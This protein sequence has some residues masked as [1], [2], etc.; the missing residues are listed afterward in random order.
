MDLRVKIKRLHKDAVIPQ[1]SKE[2]DAGLDLTAVDKYYDVNG[3]V[4]YKTGIAVEIPEG[5]VGLIYPRSSVSRV[6]LF[7]VNSVGVIDSGF[8][9]EV[10]VKFKPIPFFEVDDDTEFD[11]DKFKDVT[12]TI[13][14]NHKVEEVYV[15]AYE[16]HIGERIAQLIIMPYPKVQFEEVEELTQ[17]ERG[18]GGFGSTGK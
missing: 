5:Y 6:D 17:T 7:V 16:Y 3:C 10:T 8:R 13:L 18:D 4:V 11:K 15:E 9:G 1:Y 14:P 12:H 2:G